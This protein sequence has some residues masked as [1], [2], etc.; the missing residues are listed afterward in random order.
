MKQVMERQENLF[1]K[2]DEIVD[3]IVEDNE[4]KGVVTKLGAEYAVKAAI[5][6]TGTY[7]RGM[8]H[9]GEISFQSGPDAVAAS[10]G[11]TDKL[12]EYGITIRRFKTGTPCRINRRSI[13]FSKLEEQEGDEHITPFSFETKDEPEKYC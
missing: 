3:L 5:I 10:I 7:Q 2:Q 1:V 4:V 9:V 6:C 12:Q 8:I 13:D 11:L